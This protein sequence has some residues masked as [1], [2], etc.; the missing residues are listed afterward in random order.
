MHMIWPLKQKLCHGP[1]HQSGTVRE[2]SK[3]VPAQPPHTA[4]SA[5]SGTAGRVCPDCRRPSPQGV[6]CHHHSSPQR[7]GLGYASSSMMEFR[8]SART[9]APAIPRLCRRILLPI[10]LCARVCV[11]C[12]SVPVSCMEEGGIWGKK[13]AWNEKQ[14]L[15]P[16]DSWTYTARGKPGDGP[17]LPGLPQL[18]H[19]LD[20]RDL[21]AGGVQPAEC[22]P[23]VD[24][25][26]GA[27][28][29]GTHNTHTT[30]HSTYRPHKQETHNTQHSTHSASNQKLEPVP[31]QKGRV[32]ELGAG[33]A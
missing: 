4:P 25:Q 32:W 21:R 3:A 33:S 5:V 8:M 19:A 17:S 24:H 15:A 30:Q 13:K 7:P 27:Q 12:V 26:P 18:E 14:P 6:A 9:P 11:L 23:V 31:H 16:R 29:C 1:A 22:G 2:G 20:D 28:H 10:C